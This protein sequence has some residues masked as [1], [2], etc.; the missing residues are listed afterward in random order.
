MK[1]NHHQKKRKSFS[2]GGE[3]A[4]LK[5]LLSAFGLAERCCLDALSPLV[6]FTRMLVVGACF[7]ISVPTFAEGG[8]SVQ[9]TRIIYPQNAKEQTVR[10]SNSSTTA[11]FLVQSWVE[12]A[13]GK[14][15]DDFVVTPPLFLSTPGRENTLRLLFTGAS[16]PQYKESLYYF[17]TKQIPSEDKKELEGKNILKV[18]LATRIKLFVRPDDLAVAREDAPSLLSFTHVSSGLD[19]YN[20]TPYYLTLTHLNANG[21][22]LNDIMVNPNEHSY[23]KAPADV[24]MVVLKSLDDYGAETKQLQYTIK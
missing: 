11:S 2:Y 23:E 12:D 5:S 16:L 22:A 13:H 9:G 7:L 8:V 14:K 20:P 19:I 10:V 1:S 21:H 15:S 3:P 24:N 18:A 4:E 6:V 17:V